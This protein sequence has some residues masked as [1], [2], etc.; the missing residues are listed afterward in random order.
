MTARHTRPILCER[1]REW[2]VL[3]LDGEFSESETS[4]MH[5]HLERCDSCRR[6][7]GEVAAITAELRSA[8]LEPLPTPVALPARRSRLPLHRLQMAAA[9][10]LVLVAAGAGSLYGSLRG[11][12]GTPAAGRVVHAPMLGYADESA[13]LRR[14][15]LAE[16]KPSRPLPLGAAKPVLTISV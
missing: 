13:L 15:R 3:R 4:L 1:T 10:A 14:I 6:F 16:L 7:A 5:A 8:A 9:A 2:A 12:D 11:A